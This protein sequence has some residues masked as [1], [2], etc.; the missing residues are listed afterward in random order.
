MC[1]LHAGFCVSETGVGVV[2]VALLMSEAFFGGTGACVL[3]DA[4]G[5][6]SGVRFTVIGS[7]I[8]HNTEDDST[9]TGGSGGGA[10]L[11]ITPRDT[12][13]QFEVVVIDTKFH[14]NSGPPGELLS[15][16][17]VTAASMC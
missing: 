13:S 6:V 14:D 4:Y 3:V 9:H 16:T 17:H 8:S 11:Q 5:A 12:L 1:V 15:H 10:L 2:A 7:S